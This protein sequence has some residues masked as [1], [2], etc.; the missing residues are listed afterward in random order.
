MER[1]TCVQLLLVTGVIKNDDIITSFD[2]GSVL[3]GTEQT[4]ATVAF[5]IEV[6]VVN[7]VSKLRRLPATSDARAPNLRRKVDGKTSGSG[8]RCRCK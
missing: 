3:L 2:S 6:A 8:N 5:I 7:I 4:F 1:K